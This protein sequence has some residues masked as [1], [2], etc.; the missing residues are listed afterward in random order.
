MTRIL[1]L[2]VALVAPAIAIA[3]NTESTIAHRLLFVGDAGEYYVREAPMGSVVRKRLGASAENA[4]IIFLGDNVYPAGLSN[5]GSA[6]YEREQE[7]LRE[8]VSWVE[9][10]GSRA[11]FVP[12]NHDWQHWGKNGLEYIKNQQSWFDSLQNPLFS[13]F[14]R[15]NCPGPVEISLG[16]PNLLVIL[17][18]QWFLHKWEK[19]GEESQCDAKTREEVIGMLG[20][21]I[22]RN[23]HK[24][25]IIAGH[26]PII[27][28]GDHGGIFTWKDHLFPLTDLRPYLYVPLPVIGSIYPLYR[29]L[30]GHVQDT[31]HPLYR[32]F[33]EPIQEL[34]KK[35][36]GNLYV[37]GHEHALQYIVHDSTHFIVSGGGAK[38][39]S[40]KH[41][42]YAR[43]V[44][45]A[46][47]FVQGDLY[48]DGSMM[49]RIIQV[50]R[51]HPDGTE[52]YN[53]II[54]AID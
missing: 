30:F 4:T 44:A 26:H 25:V 28:Y 36:P 5:K 37:A 22:A 6:T 29:K 51:K 42:R 40:V 2:L 13:F 24:R 41:K 48:A 9:G 50:D 53:A 39:T 45:G 38:Y 1:V 33:R 16:G 8:Q 43:F 52:I 3:Q 14:P 17:D 7:I 27:T 20:E 15:E 23:P 34:L 18:T 54:P 12:G 35:H 11:V 47:G 21:I 46:T 49:I 19:P 10:T 32:E 31:R